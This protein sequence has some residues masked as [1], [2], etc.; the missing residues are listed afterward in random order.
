MPDEQPE[1]MP[2][3][4]Q[5]PHSG[6][7]EAEIM[8]QWRELVQDIYSQALIRHLDKDE[9]EAQIPDELVG[10]FNV[11]THG[12]DFLVR[13]MRHKDGPGI[14]QEICDCDCAKMHEVQEAELAE[15][16]AEAGEP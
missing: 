2:V 10:F 8:G 3:I 11:E 13:T 1:K 7:T 15:A 6:Q 5:A 12:D 14:L 9:I 4:N 16:E